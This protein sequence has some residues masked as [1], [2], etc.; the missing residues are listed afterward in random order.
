[1]LPASL[2]FIIATLLTFPILRASSSPSAL[3]SF[4]LNI[5]DSYRANW[6]SLVSSTY[7]PGESG[8]LRFDLVDL[9]DSGYSL[10]DAL[11]EQNSVNDPV[12][13]VSGSFDVLIDVQTV[14][15]KIVGQLVAS[16][17]MFGVYST[18]TGRAVLQS[19]YGN[20]L[21]LR[22]PLPALSISPTTEPS[23]SDLSRLSTNASLAL[24]S[25]ILPP[26]P[27]YQPPKRPLLSSLPLSPSCTFSIDLQFSRANLSVLTPRQSYTWH[28]AG[29]GEPPVG[30]ANSLAPLM[31]CLVTSSNCDLSLAFTGH[32]L[33][34]AHFVDR[35]PRMLLISP[36]MLLIS[37][38]CS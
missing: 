14:G 35:S 12:R 9:L 30:A 5:T 10:T 8:I 23:S 28:V 18:Q 7:V 19:V 4:P 34:Y 33:N 21:P 26:S 1:M 24:N 2:T 15:S 16:F 11:V 36:R 25:T 38:A 31:I 22:L 37:P 3:S 13:I 29:T 20:L 27:S 17:K 32:A 6:T